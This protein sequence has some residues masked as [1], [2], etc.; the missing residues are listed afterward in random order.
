MH[1]ISDSL[2]L[3]IMNK[4]R[5][6]TTIVE[7]QITANIAVLSIVSTLWS[8]LGLCTISQSMLRRAMSL[9][10]SFGGFQ[11]RTM[12][13]ESLL[14][15]VLMITFLRKLFWQSHCQGLPDKSTDE[16]LI[17]GTRD[18]ETDV[19]PLLLRSKCFN[20]GRGPNASAWMKSSF[21]FQDIFTYSRS[22]RMLKAFS[23]TS[24]KFEQPEMSSLFNLPRYKNAES[25]ITLKLFWPI[26][27]ISSFSKPHPWYYVLLKIKIPVLRW[28]F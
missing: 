6:Q 5:M 7:E 13:I 3:K 19:S 17:H 12:G 11:H 15:T 1:K 21:L 25:S 2:D 23:V 18:G 14:L 8:V 9:S 10:R 26:F 22:E 28:W 16:R 20:F 24:C 4:S 27:R